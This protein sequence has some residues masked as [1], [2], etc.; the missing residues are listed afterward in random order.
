MEAIH[1]AGA[2]D[3]AFLRTTF[4]GLPDAPGREAIAYHG[5]YARFLVANWWNTVDQPAVP[6]N[7]SP[8]LANEVW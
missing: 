4:T 1:I 3:L 7:I 5:D 2:E 8:E 6:V